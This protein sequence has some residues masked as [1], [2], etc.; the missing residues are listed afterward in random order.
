MEIPLK[1]IFKEEE[2]KLI[3]SKMFS[4]PLPNLVDVNEA[5]IF[6]KNPDAENVETNEMLK[7]MAKIVSSRKLAC[8]HC[9]EVFD[10]KCHYERHL[11]SH[12]IQ[13]KYRCDECEKSYKRK[14]NLD[15][16]VLKEHKGIIPF[17]CR[18]CNE[19][20]KQ[21]KSNFYLYLL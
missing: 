7:D 20:F 8:D 9:G 19:A 15:L 12:G 11:K 16:H 6:Q 14:E 10:K 1:P 4:I 3:K 18:F 5:L 21:R 2:I 17:K 13:A